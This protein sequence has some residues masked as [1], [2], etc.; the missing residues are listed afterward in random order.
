MDLGEVRAGAPTNYCL[1]TDNHGNYSLRNWSLQGEAAEPGADWWIGGWPRTP[2][3]ATC[4]EAE[5]AGYWLG[6]RRATRW[7]GSRRRATRHL[8]PKLLIILEDRK[9]TRLHSSHC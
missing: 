9:S 3:R 4:A 8:R 7:R 6:R 1:R 2:P 5:G